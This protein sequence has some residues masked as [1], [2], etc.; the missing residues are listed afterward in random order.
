[1][2]GAALIFV[3]GGFDLMDGALAK[4]KNQASPFGAFL[5]SFVDRYSEAAILGGLLIFFVR[6][7]PFAG[8][9]DCADTGRAALHYFWNGDAGV[10][11]VLIFFTMV[12]STMISYARARAGALKV[13]CEVGLLPRT[14]R[15][16]LIAL[17]LLFSL[18]TPVL[19]ILA[20]GTQITA[21]QRLMYVWEVTSGRRPR[22]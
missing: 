21:L 12:G 15:V 14:E 7:A 3:A 4:V 18:V 19:W 20:I 9:A 2:L 5:D 22:T 10:N 1:V 13:D 17:A 16:V 8:C 6:Q 11:I